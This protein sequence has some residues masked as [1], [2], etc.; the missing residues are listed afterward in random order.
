MFPLG[1]RHKQYL[2][3]SSTRTCYRPVVAQTL[4]WANAEAFCRNDGGH[5]ISL[6]SNARNRLIAQVLQNC[7]Y[8]FIFIM[9]NIY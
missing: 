3:D 9:L 2:F 4:A 8:N 5:L 7:E 6:D 1:C